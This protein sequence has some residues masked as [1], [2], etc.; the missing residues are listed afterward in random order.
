MD[1]YLTNYINNVVLF[2]VSPSFLKDCQF[3]LQTNKKTSLLYGMLV[4]VD[5]LGC[6]VANRTWQTIDAKTKEKSHH[7]AHFLI[8]WHSL[9]SVAVFPDRTFDVAPEEEDAHSMGFHA[10][11]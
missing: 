2:R 4:A 9:I 10:K 5:S 1:S 3:L 6:W 8:P 7:N 11:L